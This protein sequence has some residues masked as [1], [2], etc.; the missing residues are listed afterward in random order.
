MTPG[1]STALRRVARWPAHQR[2]GL[3]RG[4]ASPSGGSAPGAAGIFRREHFLHRVPDIHVDSSCFLLER[5]GETPVLQYP[6]DQRQRT[7]GKTLLAQPDT[8]LE[9]SVWNFQGVHALR[10]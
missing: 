1:N 3:Q 5:E 7:G 6:A 8:P 4:I 2:Y 9:T 10:R